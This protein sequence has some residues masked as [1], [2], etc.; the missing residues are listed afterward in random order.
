MSD[1]RLTPPFPGHLLSWSSRLM[2]RELNRR[3]SPLGL[4]TGQWGV[5]FVLLEDDGL[6]QTQLAARLG[7]EQPTMAAT[8]RRLGEGGW[9]RREPH[10]ADRRA[11]VVHLTEHARCAMPTVIEQ[12]EATNAQALSALTKQE[13]TTLNALLNRIIATLS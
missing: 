13:I 9:V 4:S 7:V 1:A 3:L 2:A 8:L 5:L 11:E 6:T 10:E 12:V